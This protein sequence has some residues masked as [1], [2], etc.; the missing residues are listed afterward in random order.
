[1]LRGADPFPDRICR[2]LAWAGWLLLLC[3]SAVLAKPLDTQDPEGRWT[4]RTYGREEGLGSLRINLLAQDPVGFVWAA[5]DD[6][7]YRFDGHRFRRFGEQDGL[8][9]RLINALR[10]DA[11]GQLWVG[12][13]KGPARWRGERFDAALPGYP[14][15]LGVEDI[16]LG[17]EGQLWLATRE[18]IYVGTATGVGLLA[19]GPGGRFHAVSLDPD[20]QTMWIAKPRA[21]WRWHASKGWET[22]HAEL[23]GE[24]RE[25]LDQIMA[26][27]DGR[28]WA[29]TSHHH[30]V[31]PA[32]ATRFEVVPELVRADT[33]LARMQIAADGAIWFPTETGVSRWQADHWQHW[34]L[35]QGLPTDFVRASLVD[36]EGNLWL[37]SLGL[38]RL[39][40]RGVW[41]AHTPR[42]GLPANVWSVARDVK[43]QLLVGTE[44]G[45]IQARARAWQR[46]PDTT[47]KQ[48]RALLPLD[49][50]SVLFGGK[51]Y[52]LWRWDGRQLQ[53]IPLPDDG[54]RVLRLLADGGVVWAGTY[55][56]GL[57]RGVRRNGSW[58]FVREPVP[59]GTIDERI[60][61]L[62][63]DRQ[64][65]VWATGSDG[66]ACLEAGRWHRYRAT[67][68]L[69]SNKTLYLAESA[70]GHFYLAYLDQPG[71]IST[72]PSPARCGDALRVGAGPKMPERDIYLLGETPDGALWVGHTA[73]LTRFAAPQ[74][75][76]P[77]AFR[78]G[79][80]DGLLDE[81]LNAM[82]MLAEADGRIWLGTRSGL[83]EFVP[84]HFAGQPAPPRVALLSARLGQVGLQADGREVTVAHRHNVLEVEFAAMSFLDAASVHY[85]VR[86]L[87]QE[88]AWRDTMNRESRYT[89]LSPGSYRLEVRARF[90]EG[91]WGPVTALAFQIEPPWWRTRLAMG[92][93]GLTLVLLVYLA[94]R[95]RLHRL[96][97]R[98]RELELMVTTRTTEL[99]KANQALQEQSLTDPLT[100]LR[101]RRFLGQALPTHLAEVNR[102][103]ARR[104]DGLGHGAD[105]L[106]VLVD[107]DHFKHINDQYGHAAGDLVLQRIAGVLTTTVRESDMVVRWGG[108]EFLLIMRHT[109]RQDAEIVLERLRQAVARMVITLPDGRTLSCT[110]S[111]G[112]ALYPFAV[113]DPARFDW[114]VL[115]ALA[116]RCLYVAK[117]N[118]R[119]AWVGLHLADQDLPVAAL[120]Q[121]LVD[122]LAQG[123]LRPSSSVEGELDWDEPGAPAG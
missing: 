73:G 110:C 4:F 46:V 106:L 19:G 99:A 41:R 100:G 6:G 20:G 122:L 53:A 12:T 101:N 28:V 118:G 63:K 30:Y 38:H 58:Q 64:G 83:A 50:G 85:E 54:Q 33:Y 107:I 47:D 1:M 96:Q 111:T 113:D 108:E 94:L 87:G 69:A 77:H 92:A 16:G 90:R 66:L 72:F 42:Q 75:S 88:T 14:D 97:V 91:A 26:A 116:D 86:L 18:G 3:S 22:A 70:S 119:N 27:P 78:F 115:V 89:A 44:T 32:G 7:L 102:D 103:Y 25:E 15:K 123:K 60:A 57:L 29:R 49:D 71:R 55:H 68:G 11:Q 104:A 76:E 23:F 13:D 81:E 40:G 51:P 10:L 17:P 121:P 52:G 2:W 8:P 120:S 80:E 114:E 109:L 39:V 67:D 35:A 24:T 62:L 56:A 93:A 61:H 95:W 36:R 117:R 43:G 48:V 37:G 59:G 21:L 98:T 105:L 9:G 84:A 5:T 79:L 65:R 74:A 82:A 45:L 34:G 31:R 112:F